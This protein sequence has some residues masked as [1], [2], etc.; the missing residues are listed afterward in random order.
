M[1]PPNEAFDPL[2]QTNN[3][4]ALLPATKTTDHIDAKVDY[5][6]NDAD[7]YSVRFSYEKPVIYQAPTYGDIGGPSQGA[8][9]GTGVQ[10]TYS[11]GITWDRIISP[12]LITQTRVGVAY[13]NNIATQTDYGKDDS[14]ALG[15]PGVNIN[16]FTS[17]MTTINLSGYTTPLVGYSASLPWIRAE[18]NIDLVNTWTKIA[19]NH[20]IKWGIDIRRLRDCLLQDQTFSPRGR[21]TFGANQTSVSGSPGGTSLDNDVASFL[22]GVPNDIA[23]D[24]NTYFPSLRANQIFS[25]VADT[26]QVTPRLTASIGLR[27]E[28]YPPMTPENPGGFS[29]YNP[30]DNTLVIAGVG[31]NPMDLGMNFYKRYLA[32]RLGL[33]YR[34]R[35]GN[36]GTVLRSGFGLSYTPFP[37]N[38]YAYNY[39]V[40]SNNDYTRANGNSYTAVFLPDGRLGTFANGFPAPTDVPIPSDGIIRNPDKTQAYVYIPKDYRNAYVITWNFAVQQ[41]L[42]YHFNLDVAYVG[43]HGVDTGA[44][45]NLNPGLIVGAGSAGQPYFQKFGRT[46]AETEYFQGFSSSYNSLQVKFD[47]RFSS[48]LTMTTAFT[49]QKA[50]DFQS[51]D[52]GGLARWYINPERNYARADFDK[53]LNYVQSYVYQ[54]PFGQ[55]KPHLAHGLA[56]A[57]VGGWQVSGIL[58]LRSGSPLTFTDGAGAVSLNATGNTQTPDLVAPIN[59]LHGIN[60]GNPWFD[61]A[62]F[63]MT[64]PGTFG[65]MGRAVWSG[66]SQFRLDAGLSR[67][68]TVKEGYKLQ[69]RADSYDVTNTP[70]FSNPNTDRNSSNFGYIT[71]TVGSGSGVNGFSSSRSIQFALKFTF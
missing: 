29:N 35:Q 4:F 48:G 70:F 67:W 19:H 60:I 26:W 59:I 5:Q 56:G 12:T 18:T 23:R 41:A 36:Y 68:I 37:D 66:P 11:T 44:A 27:W 16:Q 1:A 50:M 6:A 17:G 52:D 65:S 71:G 43:S 20:T 40:R 14:T 53:T 51:G 3:F 28:L 22:L 15:I 64:T 46:V 10:R 7:R 30:V 57:I 54:L 31:N 38:T 49:W 32:P 2:T 69:I 25:F 34:L 33:A 61:R 62:S 24:V 9:Q 47:R 58:T 39:P 21:F 63:A 45:T 42:P 13:Y 55:G 8:F